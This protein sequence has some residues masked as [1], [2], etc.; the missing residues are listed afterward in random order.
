M[1]NVK[2]MHD[3][4][5]SSCGAHDMVPFRPRPGSAVM[6]RTCYS[7]EQPTTRSRRP[8]HFRNRSRGNAGLP[9]A[10]S[11]QEERP[12]WDITC[13]ECGAEDS[14]P[15]KPRPGSEVFCRGCHE[16]QKEKRQLRER[17]GSRGKSGG[18]RRAVHIPRLDHG[19]R[20]SYP[21]T[22]ESCGKNETLSYVP[23]TSGP[24][25]CTECAT[26]KYGRKWYQ[27]EFGSDGREEHAITCVECGGEDT[28]PF[29]PHPDRKYHCRR[30]MDGQAQP[31]RGRLKEFKDVNSFV[32]VRR[33]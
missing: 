15:F 21:I 32:K 1:G 20:V 23:N 6:C 22:C 17:Y 33:S 12:S 14:V 8:N 25:L 29:E 16:K 9:V 19:T 18:T 5:C 7:R 27:V 11:R 30:C 26:T 13:S 28:V 31:N 2:K 3:I 10:G 4:V 24:V